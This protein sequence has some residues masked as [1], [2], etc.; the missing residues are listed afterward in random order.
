MS[1]RMD[2][3]IAWLM[4]EDDLGHDPWGTTMQWWFAIADVLEHFGEEVPSGWGYRPAAFGP[5]V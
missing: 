5:D 2:R 4:R 3:E 1:V